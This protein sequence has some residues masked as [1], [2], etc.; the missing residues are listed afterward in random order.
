MS[1]RMRLAQCASRCH[2]RAMKWLSVVVALGLVL[3]SCGSP[4]PPSDAGTD[5]ASFDAAPSDAGVDAPDDDAGLDAASSCVGPPGLYA[6]GD[7][8]TLAAGVRAYHPRFSLWADGADKERFVYLPPGGQID[9]TDPD[10]WGFPVGTRLY[11]TFSI[12]GMRLETR[13]LEKTSE[14]RGPSHWTITSYVWSADQR[15]VSEAGAFGVTGVLGTTHDVPSHVQ[16]VRCHSTGQDDVINGFS[17]V[18][19]AHDESG[20]TLAS[21]DA[22]GWLTTNVDPAQAQIPGDATARAALGYLH[23]NCGNCHGGPAAEQGFD[24]WVRVG[25]T[26]PMTSRTWATGMCACSGWAHTLPTGELLDLRIAPHHPELSVAA[27]RM[28]SRVMSEQMPPIG[29]HDVDPDGVTAIEAWITSLDET[30]G[31]CPHGCPWP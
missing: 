19:L 23:A 5:A 25:T 30:A 27:F 20:V 12:G 26:S 1:A 8:T 15:S 4:P 18:Q 17:A 2:A 9:T 13:V 14:G 28:T 21:L 29:T 7:C 24:V 16:C 6:A 22:D 3:A 31:G 11:K 10:R